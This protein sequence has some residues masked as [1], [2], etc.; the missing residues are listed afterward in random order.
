MKELEA[1]LIR[2][3]GLGVRAES[4]QFTNNRKYIGQ[5]HNKIYKKLKKL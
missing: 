2:K 3:R 5:T 1:P 4:R